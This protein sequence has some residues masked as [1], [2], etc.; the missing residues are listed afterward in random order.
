[1]KRVLKCKILRSTTLSKGE[2]Q[3]KLKYVFQI[4]IHKSRCRVGTTHTHKIEM[5]I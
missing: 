2:P 1:M 3:T 5:I 4:R